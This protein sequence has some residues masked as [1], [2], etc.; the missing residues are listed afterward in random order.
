MKEKFYRFMQGRYGVDDLYRFLFWLAVIGI[1]LNWFVKS[2]ALSFL[3]TLIL[4]YAMYRVLSR[5]HSARYTEN[6]KYLNATAKFRYWF[7]QQKKLMEERKYHHIYT[8]PKCRQ[9]I[10]IPKGK[11]KIM[12]RCPKCHH[13]FQKR[14]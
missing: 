12:V 3:T 10:R 13:E 2:S 11:G 14:S 1:V 9:K 4:V 6:Q 7:D 8:C 5:N